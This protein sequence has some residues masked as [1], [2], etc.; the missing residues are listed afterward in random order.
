[1]SGTTSEI[2]RRRADSASMA[3][4]TALLFPRFSDVVSD[5]KAIF[6]V[7]PPDACARR[8]TRVCQRSLLMC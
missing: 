5:D 8:R 2:N 1:M 3:T 4:L 7:S 6:R